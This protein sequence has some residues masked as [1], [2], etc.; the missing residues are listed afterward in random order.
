MCHSSILLKSDGGLN[1]LA[2]LLI[3][4]PVISSWGLMLQ[5]VLGK[6]YLIS[7]FVTLYILLFLFPNHK[8]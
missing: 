6:L 4:A 3:Q 5:T 2:L 8:I 7:L 1:E